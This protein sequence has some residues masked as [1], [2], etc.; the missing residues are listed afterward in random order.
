M[1]ISFCCV[2]DGIGTTTQETFATVATYGC[3]RTHSRT[4]CLVPPNS[5]ARSASSPIRL[6]R[7]LGRPSTKS[8]YY[9]DDGGCLCRYCRRYCRCRQRR[10]DT[11]AARAAAATTTKTRTA[12]SSLL[13][14]PSSMAPATEESDD[15]RRR[16][17]DSDGGGSGNGASASY[18]L[19]GGQK[20]RFWC[21]TVVLRSCSIY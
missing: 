2:V 15:N 13:R 5:A 14:P 9:R 7:Y 19:G 21:S 20:Q 17:S 18:L 12:T 6:I 10:R 4:S 16:Y 1:R 3:E 8:K 11:A